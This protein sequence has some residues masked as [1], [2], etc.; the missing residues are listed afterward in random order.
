MASVN[1]TSTGGKSAFYYRVKSTVCNYNNEVTKQP[2]LKCIFFLNG[3]LLMLRA[4]IEQNM[5]N[6]SNITLQFTVSQKGHFQGKAKQSICQERWNPVPVI[7]SWCVS[8]ET[9]TLRR[10]ISGY[11][12]QVLTCMGKFVDL[13][14]LRFKIKT[15]EKVFSELPCSF[16]V[17][18]IN[19]SVSLLGQ[20][21][22]RS[23]VTK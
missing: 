6:Q 14:F 10:P 11:F 15:Q 20:G 19:I 3:N 8:L 12:P 13:Y 23:V 9:H 17:V 2:L 4:Y 22:I 5:G 18:R 1:W 16:H 21:D 7:F